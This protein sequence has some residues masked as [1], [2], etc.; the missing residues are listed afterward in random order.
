MATTLAR[1]GD[2]TETNSISAPKG[3]ACVTNSCNVA[4]NFVIA[5]CIITNNNYREFTL[6]DAGGIKMIPDCGG[7]VAEELKGRS[8]RLS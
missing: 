1:A 6:S 4:T 3:T 7:I 5:G 2:H 8:G